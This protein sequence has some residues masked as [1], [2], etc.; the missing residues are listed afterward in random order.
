MAWS[1]VA[2]QERTI[3][4]NLPSTG[5]AVLTTGGNLPHLYRKCLNKCKAKRKSCKSILFFLT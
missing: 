5:T 1:D 3:C 2:L 4:S